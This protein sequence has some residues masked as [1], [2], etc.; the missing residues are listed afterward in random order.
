MVKKLKRIHPVKKTTRLT[1]VERVRSAKEKEAE[2]DEGL[3]AIYGEKSEDLKVVT[4]GGSRLTYWLTRIVGFL[5]FTALVIF[6]VTVLASQGWLFNKGYAP[7]ALAVEAPAEVKSGETVSITI[8]YENPDKTPLASLEVNVNVP[9]S[10]TVTKTSPAPSDAKELIFTVGSVPGHGKGVI[11]L[12]GTWIVTTPS[13]NSVQAIASYK[14]ANFSSDFS[15]IASASVSTTASVLALSLTGPETATPGAEV[16]YVVKV[17]NNGTLPAK[18][19]VVT[20]S[21]PN[22]FTVT[23]STPPVTPGERPK[24]TFENIDAG[25]DVTITVKGSYASDVTDVEKMAADVSFPVGSGLDT[26]YLVQS[27]SSVSTDV[28]GGALRLTLVGN[29]LSGDTFVAPGDALRLGYRLENTGEGPLSDAA[30]TLDFQPG[31]GIPITWSKASLDGG[32][33]S[34]DGVVFDAKKIG[35]INPSEKKSFNLSFPVKAELTST[36]VD[37]F[38][39]IAR[40][41]VAGSTIQSSP[42]TVHVNSSVGFSASA[43]YFSTDG[44]PI[45]DGPLPPVVGSTTTFE[46]MWSIPHALHP[47]EDLVVTATLP[48]G[49]TFGGNVASDLGKVTYDA[50]ANIVRFDATGITKEAGVIH[51]KFYVKATPA[52]ADV[53]KVMKILSGSALRVT[54]SVTLSR[55]EK[56]TEALTTA[57]PEDTF[58][59]GKGIVVAN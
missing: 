46:V 30:V 13:T 50:S 47:L 44:A 34:K 8:P 58:A 15:Q 55:I 23:K 33:L 32:V 43:H 56:E 38:T 59:E 41:T 12:E 2:M 49:V 51:A 6:G 10:F 39:V 42:L 45:G 7:L 9:P 11:T 19:A 54:D 17:T 3:R 28:S 4:R 57:L 31:T 40:A 5:A 25:K 21:A 35:V 20:L 22:G 24:W 16:S 48:P 37:T 26:K 29:G 1:R 14:P 18:G 52:A 53:G 36:D 27:G